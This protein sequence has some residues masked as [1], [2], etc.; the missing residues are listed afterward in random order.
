[1]EVEQLNVRQAVIKVLSNWDYSKSR[2]GPKEITR[3]IGEEFG[4]KTSYNYVQ[5]VL[6]DLEVNGV[7]KKSKV[8]REVSYFLV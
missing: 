5:Q 4:I 3:K 7:V 8:G 6:L 1:M 2:A